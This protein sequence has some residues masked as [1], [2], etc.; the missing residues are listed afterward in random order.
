MDHYV[1]GAEAGCSG[2]CCRTAVKRIR[3]TELVVFSRAIYPAQ[4]E[5]ELKYRVIVTLFQVTRVH[6]FHSTD[7]VRYDFAE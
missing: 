1:Q 7:G 2:P 6:F 3:G 4:R 5:L